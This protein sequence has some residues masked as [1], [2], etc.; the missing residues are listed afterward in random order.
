MELVIFGI[1]IFVVLRYLYWRRKYHYYK[2]NK[3]WNP[4]QQSKWQTNKEKGDKYEQQILK[5]YKKQGYKVYPQGF[6]KGK[7]DGGIDLIAYKGNE[8]L[9]IQC[10]NWEYSQVKQEHLRI[11]LGDCTAYLEKNHN[12]FAKKKVKRVFVTSCKNIDYGVQKFVEENNV[13]YKI[14]P[15][16]HR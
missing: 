5:L 10:K 14:I 15:Y 2:K 3:W 16:N 13:E 1:G 6:I 8:A 4:P 9:L 11:F 12:I 7:A